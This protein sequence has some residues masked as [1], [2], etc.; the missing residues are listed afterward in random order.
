MLFGLNS[1]DLV[2][3]STHIVS[4]LFLRSDLNNCHNFTP[5]LQEFFLL[6]KGDHYRGYTHG[7]GDPDHKCLLYFHCPA[8]R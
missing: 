2:V 4:K 6:F 5:L 8:V 7:V 3:E 1:L